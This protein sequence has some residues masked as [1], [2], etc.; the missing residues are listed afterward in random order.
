MKTKKMNINKRSNTRKKRGG[1]KFSPN[2]KKELQEAVNYYCKDITAGRKRYGNI[3]SWDVS[4]INDMSGLFKGDFVDED[5]NNWDVSNVTNMEGMFY[6]AFS[7]NQPLNNWN[8]G[9]VTNMKGM[10]FN[11]ESFNQ[12]LNNWNISNVTNM[13]DMFVNAES[14]NQ[15]LNNWN[16]SNVTNMEGMFLNAQLFNQPLNNWDVGN[17]TNMKG[18]FYGAFSFNQPLNNW[19]VSNVT[20]M[21]DM[22]VNAESFNQPLNNWNVSNVTNMQAMFQNAQSFNQPL[23]NWDVTNVTNM[24]DMFVNAQSFN[25]PLNNWNIGNETNIDNMFLGADAYTYGELQPAP[26]PIQ[27]IQPILGRAYEVHNAFDNINFDLLFNTITENVDITSLRNTITPTDLYDWLNNKLSDNNIFNQTEEE[28]R[29]L[30]NNLMAIRNKLI[31]MDFTGSLGN[32]SFKKF[33]EAIIVFV[34]SQPNEFIRNYI[35]SYI[36][37]NIGAYGDNYDNNSTE[38]NVTTSSCVKGMKERIILNLRSGGMGLDNPKYIKISKI[39]GR[40]TIVEDDCETNRREISNEMIA[41]F[42]SMCLNNPEI[43][44]TQQLLT[45]NDMNIRSDMLARCILRKLAD[46]GHIARQEVDNLENF[47]QPLL[48]RIRNYLRGE[49]VR[50]MYGDDYLTGGK[51]INIRRKT[52]K[53][54]K[55]NNNKTKRT[56]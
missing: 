1:S 11:A 40:E 55:K 39:I 4:R 5:I 3:G 32:N 48:T 53:E 56:R 30:K 35:H 8:V 46:E 54:N 13:E 29:H 36:K 18:M 47:D 22:F 45:V 17:V 43:N 15:P 6:N 27:P 12:S 14:F 19:N 42:T 44:I 37:D 33:V 28:T 9:N 25:Q 31:P 34:N 10:F 21:E 41:H 24:E 16:V 7:F 2:T 49:G 26:Q 20:N 23:N 52:R 50:E 51:R 38:P